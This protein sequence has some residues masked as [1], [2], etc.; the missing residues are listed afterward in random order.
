MKAAALI[1]RPKGS[2]S[3]LYKISFPRF[4]KNKPS[5]VMPGDHGKVMDQHD[6]S[7]SCNA[8]SSKP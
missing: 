6:Q 1:I 3:V 7:D 4:H 5:G 2:T 8:G